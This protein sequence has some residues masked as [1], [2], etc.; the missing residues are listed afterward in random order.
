MLHADTGVPGGFGLAVEMGDP[1]TKSHPG[2]ARFEIEPEKVE[3]GLFKLVLSLVELI[4]QLMEKQA[5]RRIEAGSLTDDEAER[6]GQSL[7][8]AEATV[9]DLKARFGIDDLNI[10]LGPMGRLI[11]E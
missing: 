3:R 10:D 11:D 7:M 6:L 4:R 5:V 1:A 9:H 8:Q 2:C